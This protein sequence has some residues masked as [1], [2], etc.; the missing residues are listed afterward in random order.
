MTDELN[1]LRARI[2]QLEARAALRD[3]VS[4]YCHGFDKGDFKRFLSIW[5]ED[6]D[7]T[8]AAFGSF[9]TPALRRRSRRCCGPSGARRIT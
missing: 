6:C 3:L 5:W 9:V 1:V 4:D 2:D 7:G 8:S